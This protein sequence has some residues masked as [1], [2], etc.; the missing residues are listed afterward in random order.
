MKFLHGRES[1]VPAPAIAEKCVEQL[2]LCNRSEH[3]VAARNQNQSESVCH[4]TA[5][6][7]ASDLP[8]LW[9]WSNDKELGIVGASIKRSMTVAD[10]S[11]A[12]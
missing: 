7:P 9:V 3:S 5:L 8:F 6:Y 10:E 11:G 12:R 1:S 4:L 2:W